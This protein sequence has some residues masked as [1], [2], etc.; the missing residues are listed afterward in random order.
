MSTQRW[1]DW[2]VV[3][4]GAWLLLSPLLLEYTQTTAASNATV[5][6][7]G[8]MLFAILSL[9][10][11]H[12]WEEWINFAL[13]AWLIASPF[14]LGHSTLPTPTWNH[15]VVGLIAGANALLVIMRPVPEIRA[16]R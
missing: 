3:A 11:S 4:L 8:M 7:L 9:V 16:S 2:I 10:E 12:L 14:V 5:I 6:G 1:P 15:V 13:G